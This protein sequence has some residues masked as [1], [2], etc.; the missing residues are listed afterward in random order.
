MRIFS[1]HSLDNSIP[2]ALKVNSSRRGLNE[3]QD[4]DVLLAHPQYTAEQPSQSL[5]GSV[6][7]KLYSTGYITDHLTTGST[8][9]EGIAQLPSQI[10][11]TADAVRPH[12]RLCFRLVPWDAFVFCQLHYTGSQAF[13]RHM[14][15][16]AAKMGYRLSVENL[17]KRTET[18]VEILGA[19][20]LRFT[21]QE[22]RNER[23]EGDIVLLDSEEDIFRFLKMKF[24][25]PH[26]RNW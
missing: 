4:I 5:L 21:E 22:T 23:E 26:D 11:P 3:C 13:I 2:V 17:E 19:D 1:A 10:F 7:D 6:I 15:E 14:R 24:I 18:A 20:A 12:R 25:P 9:Y 16:K 8:H